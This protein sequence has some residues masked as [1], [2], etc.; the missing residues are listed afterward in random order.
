MPTVS[1]GARQLNDP[2]ALAQMHQRSMNATPD[3]SRMTSSAVQTV[4]S[5][6]RKS[7]EFDVKIESQGL[8]PSQLPSSSSN[9]VSQETER[10]SIHVQ[11]LNRQQQQHLHFQTAYGSSGDNYNPFSG[12]TSSS[13]SSIKPQPHDSHMSQSQIPHQSIGS[14]HLGG[15][16]HGLN[17]VGMS[18]PEQQNSFSDPKRLPG[19]SV[20]PAINNTASPQTSNAWQLSTNKEQ[21]L[22]LMPSAS[23][24]K[25]EPTD[26]ST[27][28]R[29]SA[30]QGTEKDEFSRGLPS[31]KSMPPTTSTGLLP[32]NSASPS[33]M[34]QLDSNV[35]VSLRLIY[36]ILCKIQWPNF[37]DQ[38]VSKYVLF[39]RAVCILL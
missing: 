20:C 32:L 37:V 21:N 3:Q 24:V 35:S 16:A 1:P 7:Q 30:N 9:A 5:N 8:Q 26:L 15:A 34:T 2:H 6:A 27:E 29:H 13:N 11:G 4:E 28:H 19:G 12:T 10:S 17:V 23:Y 22:G 31:S 36:M 39:S 14:N 25:K 33:A 18:K 38:T